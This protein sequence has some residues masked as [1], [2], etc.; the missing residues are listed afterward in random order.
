MVNDFNARIKEWN[1]DKCIVDIMQTLV[2]NIQAYTNLA[3]NQET[4]I[5]TLDKLHTSN[6]RFHDFM[7]TIDNT[8]PTNMMT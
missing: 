8:P 4:I 2:N 7:L 1:T 5:N 3:N 6:S